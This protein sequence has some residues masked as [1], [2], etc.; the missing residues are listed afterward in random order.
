MIDYSKAY[1]DIKSTP[2]VDANKS[3]DLREP[4]GWMPAIAN[5]LQKQD[6]LLKSNFVFIYW[7]YDFSKEEVLEYLDISDRVYDALFPGI[8]DYFKCTQRNSIQ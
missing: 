2:F 3:F 6:R 7:K 8:K 4:Y 5:R 1:E